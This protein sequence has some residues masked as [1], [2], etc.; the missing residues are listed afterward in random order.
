MTYMLTS[1]YATHNPTNQVVST[2]RGMCSVASFLLSLILLWQNPRCG[3]CQMDGNSVLCGRNGQR[4][5]TNRGVNDG[6]QTVICTQ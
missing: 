2:V 4:N 1:A 6:Q 5:G 3:W